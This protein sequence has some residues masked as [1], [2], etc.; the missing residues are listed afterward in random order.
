M[1]TYTYYNRLTLVHPKD[2]NSLDISKGRIIAETATTGK[3]ILSDISWDSAISPNKDTAIAYNTT[4][5]IKIYEP[6]GVRLLDYIR[7]A[8]LEVG[9]DNHL[10]ARFFLEM[11]IVAETIPDNKQFRYIWPIMFLATEVKS[12]VNERGTEY[13]IKFIHTGQHAQTDMVQPIKEPLKIDGVSDV[14]GYF[15]EF[16]RKLEL[17]EFKY[18]EAGQK[19]G[20]GGAPGGDHPAAQ[21]PYHDEFHFIVDPRIE[22]YHLSTKGPSDGAVQGSWTRFVPFVQDHF[23]VSAKSGTTI[24]S[25]IQRVLASCQESADL[26]LLNYGDMPGAGKSGSQSSDANKKALKNAMGKIYN[27]FRVETHSVYKEFDYIRGRYAVKHVF[28]IYAALQP[29]LYQYPDELDELNK[30]ENKGKVEQ[31]LKAYI[32]EGLL[33]KAYYYMYTG[34]NTEILKLNLQLNQAYYLPS[35]PMVWTDRGTAGPGPM[36]PYNYNRNISPYARSGE[37]AD[38]RNAIVK[39]QKEAQKLSSQIQTEKDSS[40]KKE[41][42]KQLEQRKAAID[43]LKAKTT[44]QAAQSTGNSPITNRAELLD[45][46]KNL[47]VEDIDYK[48]GLSVAAQYTPGHRPRMEPDEPVS[49]LDQKK[50]ENDGL[51]D[52]I[53]TVQLAARDL[54]ELELEVRADPYW[55]GQPNMILSGKKYIDKLDLPPALLQRINSEIPKIDPD[56][57]TRES[58]WGDYDQA[59]IYKGGNLFYLNCQLPV[60]DFGEDDTMKFD[61]IDQV[62]GI[63]QVIKCKNE[64]KNGQWT[65]TLNCI[66]DLTIPSKFLPRASIGETT[67]EDYVAA[68]I[69][70]PNRALDD[71][72][73]KKTEEVSSRNTQADNQGLSQL[74]GDQ[75]MGTAGVVPDSTTSTKPDIKNAQSLFEKKLASNPPPAVTPPV[76]YANS[77]VAQGKS[78]QEAYALAKE[79]FNK[80]NKDYFNHL[81]KV[82]NEAYKEAGVTNNKPYSS[83]TL[84][85]LVTQRSGNG[86]LED[87]KANNTQRPGAWAL[88][89]PGG[90]GFD[91]KT[92]RANQY[93]TYGDG[94]KAVNNYYN[95]GSSVS[96]NGR[97]GTDRYLLPSGNKGSEL[98]YIASKSK[99]T[100]Q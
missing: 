92:G 98:D 97:Q 78:K 33:R 27:F 68:A 15:K 70:D 75:G 3:F 63:Y 95:Y 29:T 14:Q 96:A 35:F 59:K 76:D 31:K 80:E 91:A 89:N 30:P 99:G 38:T 94:M 24:V 67:F 13:N 74:R 79:K 12:S 4:G 19:A 1:S 66:R 17:M 16:G 8:A 44:T 23:T 46:L 93:D 81:E 47:Y 65:Q 10:D 45:S 82:N 40:K 87:W 83:N 41:L 69:A 7:F 18:A 39:N 52:K 53:F 73:T 57:A 43:E 51:M 72:K 21:D 9:L 56:Y 50:T 6:L 48:Q 49:K 54:V 2:V 90:L 71:M 34:L 84:A 88:N 86:G 25:Q 5:D 62:I 42:Q 64:F 32:Q 28:I 11:E 60:N 55:L 85:G 58:S 100:R 37:D 22:K 61:Q 36:K 20:K 26:Y 77:L